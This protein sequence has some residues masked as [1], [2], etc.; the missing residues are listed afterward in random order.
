MAL[1]A[2]VMFLLGVIVAFIVFLLSTVSFIKDYYG[3][4]AA[5]RFWKL[6]FKE[7]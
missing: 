6:L 5:K 3:E 7:D 1:L 4:E 2:F